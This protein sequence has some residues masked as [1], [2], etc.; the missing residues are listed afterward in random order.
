MPI[1]IGARFGEGKFGK[2]RFSVVGYIYQSSDLGSYTR[3]I[4][5]FS[6]IATDFIRKINSFSPLATDVKKKLLN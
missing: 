2:S 6:I 3:K 1:I 4:D 5:L